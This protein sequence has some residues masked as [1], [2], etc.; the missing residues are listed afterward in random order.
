MQKERGTHLFYG[1]KDVNIYK[2]INV[3]R[4]LLHYRKRELQEY[5]KINN[6]P[7]SIDPS[8]E[9]IKFRRNYFRQ[10]L[11]ELS[12]E[13]IRTI[14]KDIE[15]NNV[16]LQGFLK[17]FEKN[18]FTNELRIDS[19]I[20]ETI[21]VREFQILLIYFLKKNNQFKEISYTHAKDLLEKFKNKKNFS[22][23][24]NDEFELY[25]EYGVIGIFKK[26]TSYLYYLS[27][28]KEDSIFLINKNH[29]L[30]KTLNLDDSCYIAP[31]Y[32]SEFYEYKGMRMKVNREFISWKLP[33]HLRKLWPGIYTKEGHLVYLPRYR[34]KFEK[35][36]NLLSFD[37]KDII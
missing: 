19:I 1:I 31:A 26:A 8:N 35:K 29:D 9:D 15:K 34:E 36:E 27:D 4:P 18:I 16:V 20:L 7:F 3:I 2:N 6:V 25:F 10:K 30:Y 13:E 28:L 37:I 17:K 5:C 11:Q 21:S 22:I 24:L 32:H 14:L 33:L 12:D 23:P